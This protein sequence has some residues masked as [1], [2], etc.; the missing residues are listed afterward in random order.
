MILL[1]GTVC[2]AQQPAAAPTPQP[3]P[4]TAP[5]GSSGK[6]KEPPVKL[7][8]PLIK[9]Q[10]ERAHFIAYLVA[11][12]SGDNREKTNFQLKIYYR[13]KLAAVQPEDESPP[14]MLVIDGKTFT[15]A[16]KNSDVSV[17]ENQF[18]PEPVTG[19]QIFTFDF[20]PED[21][22]FLA[23]AKSLSIIWNKINAEIRPEGLETLHKFVLSEASR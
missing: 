13:E 2:L 8:R 12:K 22:D 3:N 1:T 6:A 7:S 15:L 20:L 4:A 10:N 11:V 17:S 16:A 9:I 5:T 19:T 21:I 18:T 14:A 23:Q